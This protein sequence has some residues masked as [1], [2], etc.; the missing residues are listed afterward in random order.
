MEKLNQKIN[1]L[2]L[3][4]GCSVGVLGGADDVTIMSTPGGAETIFM[5]GIRDKN[6]QV[7][8]NAKSLNQTNCMDALTKIY[9]SLERLPEDAIKSD[10]GSFDFQEITTASLP[11]IV[12]QD[13]Q[14]Y[15]VYALSISAKI[16]I[17]EGVA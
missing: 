12:M 16:T 15:F 9:Q 7:Q 8:V 1:C 3:F 14:G 4:T 2:D 13:E 10:N 17:Y 11:S 5:D 6:Y